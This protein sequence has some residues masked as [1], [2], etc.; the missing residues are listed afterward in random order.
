MRLILSFRNKT[1]HIPFDEDFIQKWP[2]FTIQS[3]ISH[4]LLVME[5]K[6]L[7]E[8]STLKSNLQR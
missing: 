2:H 3:K 4:E 1:K 5:E 8:T 6:S 7:G